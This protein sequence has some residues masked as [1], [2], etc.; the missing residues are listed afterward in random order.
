[1]G[2]VGQTRLAKHVT[3]P[4]S[5]GWPRVVTNA[6]LP[7]GIREYDVLK[8]F[9]ELFWTQKQFRVVKFRGYD[10][11]EPLVNSEVLAVLIKDQIVLYLVGHVKHVSAS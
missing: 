5:Q 10:D 9:E 4:G 2:P 6:A 8:E 7:F 11:R 3:A 1:M